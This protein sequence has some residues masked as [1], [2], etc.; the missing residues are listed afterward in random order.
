MEAPQAEMSVVGRMLRVFYAPSETFEAVSEQRSAADWLVPT[1]LVAAVV[2]VAALLVLP[3][4]TEVGQEAMQQQMKD[5]SAEEREMVEKFQGK[6]AAQTATL[7][8]SPI[9]MFIYLFIAAAL[10][11]VLGKLLGGLLSYGQALAIMAY[12]GLVTLPQ[13]VVGALLI[14]ARKMPEV[15]MG[16]GLFLSEEALQSFGGR[17]LASIDPFLVWW[18]VIVGLGLSIVGNLDRNRAYIGA[19]VLSLIWIA[20]FAGFASLGAT[21]TTKG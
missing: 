9:A 20:G 4:V 10:C 17:F 15:Q 7:I 8:A 12:A 21:F 18:T 14:S 5:M 16:L 11:L 2:T 13:Q 3:I 19:I 6:G 1:A